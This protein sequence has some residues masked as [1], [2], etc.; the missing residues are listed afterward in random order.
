MTQARDHARHAIADAKLS[1]AQAREG[2][3]HAAAGEVEA[4]A[5]AA[6]AR[7]AASVAEAQGAIRDIAADG[8]VAIVARLTGAQPDRTDAQTRVGA[9]MGA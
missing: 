3:L 7:I 4:Q 6:E 5:A 9:L 8:A 2:R 1:A